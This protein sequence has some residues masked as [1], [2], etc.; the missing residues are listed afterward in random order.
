MS[1]AAENLALRDDAQVLIER[2]QIDRELIT[3]L[4]LNPDIREVVNGEGFQVSDRFMGHLEKSIKK[5]RTYINDQ[6][7]VLEAKQADESRPR[8][9]ESGNGWADW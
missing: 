8:I 9:S 6:V 5:I 3:R 7:H 2:L 4:V 1:Q